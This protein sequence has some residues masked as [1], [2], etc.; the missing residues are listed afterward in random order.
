MELV[1][2]GLWLWQLVSGKSQPDFRQR[3]GQTRVRAL[4]ARCGQS[5]PGTGAKLGLWI[6]RLV[7]GKLRSDFACG[8][9]QC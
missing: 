7:A 9:G 1:K 2:L 8:P 5:G 4:A 3:P 6:R